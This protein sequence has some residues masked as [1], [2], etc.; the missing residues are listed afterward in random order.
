MWNKY[1]APLSKLH[2]NSPSFTIEEESSTII[3]YKKTKIT[4]YSGYSDQPWWKYQFIMSLLHASMDKRQ[5]YSE[6][7]NDYISESSLLFAV[8]RSKKKA[9]S[10]FWS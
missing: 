5:I 6:C 7:P 4:N 10:I 2:Y 9:R 3:K 1:E 8:A